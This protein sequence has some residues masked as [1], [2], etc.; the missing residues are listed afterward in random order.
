MPQLLT[1]SDFAQHCGVSRQAV[2][3]ACVLSLA[4]AVVGDRIDA[5]HPAAVRYYQRHVNR[6]NASPDGPPTP[7]M[8]M[9]VAAQFTPDS[10]PTSPP[11][12]RPY[13]QS[14]PTEKGSQEYGLDTSEDVEFYADK[15]LREIVT[16]HGTHR[17]VKDWVDVFKKLVDIKDRQLSNAEK[18]GRLISRELVKT[19]MLASIDGCF[20]RLLQD[21]PK[22]LALQI[23]ALV[24][25]GAGLEDIERLIR[26]S[27][28]KQLRPMK[29]SL[30]RALTKTEQDNDE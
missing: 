4:P 10:A 3:Q 5:E 15:T 6:I 2:K 8:G 17:S 12:Q 25:S 22:S 30:V 18:E 19:F 14:E 11:K 29:A 9:P 28:T 1:K 27:I 13:V 7:P 26:E 21:T 16:K 23:D 24:K 20:R